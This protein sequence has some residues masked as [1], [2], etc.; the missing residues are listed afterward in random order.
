M[1]IFRLASSNQNPIE[2]HT[3]L[4]LFGHFPTYNGARPKNLQGKWCTLCHA[5][6]E[7]LST[8]DSG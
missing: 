1:T 4:L 7:L 3:V 2:S 6:S 8:D 5:F